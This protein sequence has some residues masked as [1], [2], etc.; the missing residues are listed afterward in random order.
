MR[1]RLSVLA[2]LLVL[3][4]P[5]VCAAEIEVYFSPNGG[6][7][8]AII[9]EVNS[10]KSSINVA[11][12]YLTERRISKGLIAGKQR[13]VKVSVVLDKSQQTQKYSKAVYLS[14]NGIRPFINSKYSIMHNKYAIVDGKTVITGS[15]NWTASV[16]A[17]NAENLLIIRDDGVAGPYRKNFD[18]LLAESHE[19]TGRKDEAKIVPAVPKAPAPKKVQDVTVYIT[20]TGKKY[21]RAGCRYLSK[22]M[23]PIS[24][25]DAKARGYGPCSVCGPPQ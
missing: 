24:L 22:S 1:N 3:S 2:L 25:K 8:D 19:F 17:K 12:Y 5:A 6:C 14:N 15:Y 23:I 13:G 20:R 10:A 16:E 4:L 9:K 11:M 18:K 21:H 7:E